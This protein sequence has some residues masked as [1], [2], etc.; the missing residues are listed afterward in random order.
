MSFA[1]EVFLAHR[2]LPAPLKLHV[3]AGCCFTVAVLLGLFL[4]LEPG[5]LCDEGMILFM[6]G[7][8]DWGE[9]NLFFMPKLALLN[10]TIFVGVAVGGIPK[11]D[12]R[13]LIPHLVALVFLAT[14]PGVSDGGNCDTYYG[15]P[16]GN[17]AQMLI[18]QAALGALVLASAPLLWNRRMPVQFLTV[19]AVM[20][21][22]VGIFYAW[23]TVT[24]HW[25]W[26][27]TVLVSVSWLGCAALL[28]LRAR[29][30]A[31]S[32]G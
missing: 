10:T 9:T 27:H 4:P 19:I 20:L 2:A 14:L 29:S 17:F 8:C 30:A 6:E 21:A 3:V 28:E 26:L 25:T 11:L 31:R 24:P 12:R 32:P 23:L 7:G 22:A 16:N 1:H 15:H 13:G 18:E 5:P